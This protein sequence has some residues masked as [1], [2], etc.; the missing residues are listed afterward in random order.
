[1]IV[2]FVVILQIKCIF[3]GI[4]FL[5]GSFPGFPIIQPTT[6]LPEIIINRDEFRD[7]WFPP[8]EWNQAENLPEIIINRDQ[9]FRGNFLRSSTTGMS[10]MPGIILKELHCLPGRFFR[11]KINLK[12][13][14]QIPTIV[15]AT[16]NCALKQ[17][18]EIVRIEIPSGSFQECGVS[19]CGDRDLCLRLRFPTV[20]GLKTASDHLV[21]LKCHPQQ[22]LVIQ[23][24][25]LRV[26][27]IDNPSDARRISAVLEGGTQQP[28]RSQ[29]A[30]FRR[31][32]DGTFTEPLAQG[33][34]VFLGEDLMLRAQVKPQDGWNLTGMSD[35]F[36]ARTS[37][38]GEVLN[39]AILVTREGCVNPTMRA[40]CPEEPS[41]DPPLGQKFLFKAATFP[42]MLPDEE[43]VLNVRV[44][45]CLNR[46]DCVSRRCHSRTGS[47]AKRNLKNLQYEIS[48]ISF[49]VVLPEELKIH[50]QTD[51]SLDRKKLFRK[52]GGH[53]TAIFSLGVVAIF[54][55]G[56]TILLGVL[57]RKFNQIY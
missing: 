18:G 47:R 49:R 22:P 54:C 16:S 36:L 8:E 34:E 15:G 31:H 29:I 42:E 17:N 1:M 5:P 13:S 23:D 39:S 2:V 57:W 38:S 10:G 26:L 6:S 50:E 55:L 24:H 19:L 46:L 7:F 20:V 4:L 43:I 27:A 45:G 3:G 28:F 9:E 48:R 44:F 21:T 35:I 41:F 52:S 12:S 25:V 56:C 40:I 51:G 33:A 32:S 11:A 37:K 30:L 14:M 53:L